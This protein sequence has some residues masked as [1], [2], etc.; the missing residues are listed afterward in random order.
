MPKTKGGSLLL[1]LCIKFIKEL[2][3]K[4]DLTHIQLKDNSFIYCKQSKTTIDFDSFYMLTHGNTW[5]GKYGFV[6]Y[7]PEQETLDIDKLVSYKLNQKLVNIVKVGCINIRPLIEKAVTKFKLDNVFTYN[8]INKM[9][10]KY[11]DKPL[12]FFMNDLVK[13]YDHTCGIFNEIYKNVMEQA[14]MINLHGNTY[15][16]PLN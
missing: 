1:R 5:Y 13:E 10:K 9:M 16:L 8:F 15:Y 12:Q 4:Y 7:D 11:E 6:P 14:G 2:K 3:N